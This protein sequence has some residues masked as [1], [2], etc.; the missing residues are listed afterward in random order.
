[1]VAVSYDVGGVKLTLQGKALAAASLGERVQVRNPA[2]NKVIQAVATG[3]GAAVVGPEADRLK[4]G[5]LA[6]R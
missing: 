3:P 5:A 2:S 1:M 6:S 4:A